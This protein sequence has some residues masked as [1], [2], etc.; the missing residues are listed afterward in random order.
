[1]ESEEIN[2]YTAG[3]CLDDTKRKAGGWAYLIKY[4]SKEFGKLEITASGNSW[5][6]STGQMEL[7]AVLNAIRMTT[8]LRRL[9]DVVMVYPYNVRIAQCLSKTFDCEN[10]RVLG[11]YLQE[12]GWATGSL[13]I[14]Y[15]P[16]IQLA[17]RVYDQ[18]VR[19]QQKLEV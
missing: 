12:I 14:K 7:I 16:T 15:V 9:T 10:E 4:G 18:A 6:T 3:S 8:D 1:M 13:V 5:G 11:D 17:S 2:I 19:E